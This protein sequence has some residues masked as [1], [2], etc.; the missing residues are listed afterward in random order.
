M[1][2]ILTDDPD[3]CGLEMSLKNVLMIGLFRSNNRMEFLSK[4]DNS[5]HSKHA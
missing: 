3:L 1:P 4:T 2:F 5:S